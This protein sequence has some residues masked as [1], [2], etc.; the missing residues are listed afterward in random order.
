MKDS[1]LFSLRNFP[2]FNLNSGRIPLAISPKGHAS[3]G[4]ILAMPVFSTNL[5]NLAATRLINGVFD[6]TTNDTLVHPLKL[7]RLR[8]RI[9]PPLLSRLPL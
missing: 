7:G 2:C 4:H 6:E 1:N 9:S 3:N 5:A 8:Y